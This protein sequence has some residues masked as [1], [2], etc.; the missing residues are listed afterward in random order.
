VSYPAKA[1]ANE[2]LD[3][4][5]NSGDSLSAMKLQKLVYFAHGWHLALMNQ[6]LLQE[7]VQA[8][9][10]GPVVPELYQAF[11]RF[12]SEAVTE[13][14]RE[15]TLRNHKIVF[16][17]PRIADFEDDDSNVCALDVVRKVWDT[18]G[19][20]GA[21]KLSNATHMVGTP[22]YQ[23]YRE[24]QRH[25]VIPNELIKEYFKSMIPG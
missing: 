6:P 10:F 18:Y 5:E 20:Y 19:K 4:A 16:H 15:M 22:W 2:F 7:N 3:I 24:G 13:P 25:K 17:A 12:G 21:V 9:Q 14:A 1:V 11:K 8:W 23:V